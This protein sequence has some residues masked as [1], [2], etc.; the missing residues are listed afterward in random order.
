M[1]RDLHRGGVATTESAATFAAEVRYYLMQE[2]R[3]LPSRFLYDAL[4]SALFE[5]ICQLPWYPLTRA[6]LALLQAHGGE[7][8]DADIDVVLEL[9]AGSG[10][11]LSTLIRAGGG[12][13]R[14]RLELIDVSPQALAQASRAVEEVVENATVVTHEA[15]YEAGLDAFAARRRSH[16]RAMALFL[17]SN[18]G[19]FDPPGREALLVALRR[20]LCPG[21]LLLL[22][23]DLVKSENALLS[24]YDDPLGVTAAFNRN[25]IV[26]INRELGGTFDLEA[27]SHRAVWNA[28]ERRVEMHLVCTRDQDLRIA[29]SGLRFEMK[30]GETIWTE[31]SYKFRTP[32]IATLLERTGFRINGQWLDRNAGFALT[33]AEAV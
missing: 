1:I 10:E 8:L 16:G 21:D 2:P 23:V 33:R 11:K 28:A 31:S 7:I 17:G 6:E 27:F 4:G 14:L 13:E 5:A 19:N 25:L 15:T 30:A 20:A 22:G 29:A 32:E 9:G 24:A 26:R 3:Q 18:L 12:R